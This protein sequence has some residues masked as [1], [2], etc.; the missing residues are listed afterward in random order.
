MGGRGA[1]GFRWL[2]V[3]MSHMS[4]DIDCHHACLA[5]VPLTKYTST[6]SATWADGFFEVG[7]LTYIRDV[8][9]ILIGCSSVSQ[10]LCV[11]CHATLDFRQSMFRV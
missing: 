8:R 5:N 2:T 1:G 9:S 7:S 4:I 10:T 11:T 6:A 3:Q